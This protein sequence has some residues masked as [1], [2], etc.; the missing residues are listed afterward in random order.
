[1]VGG[2]GDLEPP[3][4]YTWTG[5]EP[6]VTFE[7][8]SGWEGGHTHD[9]FFDVWNGA[10]VGFMRPEHLVTGNG[11][12][13]STAG[14]DPEATIGAITGR[15]GVHTEA[16][17]F[18]TAVGGAA[19]FSVDVT[20]QQDVPM[21]GLE[22]EENEVPVPKGWRLRYRA[23]GVANTDGPGFTTVLV[24]VGLPKPFDQEALAG[25]EDVVRTVEWGPSARPET[26]EG[27]GVPLDPGSY[28]NPA[29][30]PGVSF[31]VGDGWI[32]AHLFDEFFDVEREGLSVGFTDPEL[33]VRPDG[34]TVPEERLDAA[35]AVR[36]LRQ[37]LRLPASAAKQCPYFRE[38]RA[39]CVDAVP[40][41]AV[42][43]FRGADGPF[44]LEPGS[45]N[46]FA[47]VEI[48][49]HIA[50]GVVIVHAGPDEALRRAGERVMRTARWG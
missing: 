9:D 4:A 3:G 43:V 50:M 29:Y 11:K 47:V 10:F 41:T 44:T 39:V 12:P 20:A 19:G 7:V 5:F 31:D 33:F 45:W 35:G 42:E 6:R 49:D 46:R 15:A 2:G 30:A 8:P 23:V 14:M 34:G 16:G 21:F 18:R 26:M 38:L 40:A 37:Q 27:G 32:G 36:I 24:V 22:G 13:V 25:A 1:M 17:P 28:T 48:D